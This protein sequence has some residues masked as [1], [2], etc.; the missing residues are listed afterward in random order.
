M[1]KSRRPPLLKLAEIQPGQFADCFAQLVEKRRGQTQ[2]GKPYYQLRFRDSRRTVVV[3]I[4][5]DSELFETCQLQW[6][7]GQFFKLRG[8][9]ME[10]ERYGPQLEVEAIRPV[11]ERDREDGFQE[12]DFIQ[13]SRH[14]PEQMYVQLVQWVEQE[15]RTG[16]LRELVLRLLHKYEAELKPL[17]A[18][19]RRYY[20]F[21]GGWLEHTLT[22]ARHSVWLADRYIQLYPELQPPIN[23]DLIAAAAVLHDIGRVRELDLSGGLPPRV[24][25]AGELFGHLILAHDMIRSAAAEVADLSAEMLELL[26]HIVLAHLRLPEWG[27]TRLPCIPEVLILHHA[28]DLDAKL[29]MYIRCL[30]TDSTDGPFT[31]RDPILGRPLLKQRSV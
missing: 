1:S 6:Q 12:R 27:S 15:I 17:P 10:H 23:R 5:Q 13:T 22:V 4:W 14:D 28:D 7:V 3:M 20:P 24:S 8:T 2:S 25:V 9:F 26:L 19:D 21:S 31:E 30:T 29:E 18:S 16:P 11:E